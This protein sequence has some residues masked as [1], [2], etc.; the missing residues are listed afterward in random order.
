V[1]LAL[2]QNSKVSGSN[3]GVVNDTNYF[4]LLRCIRVQ[5]C[6]FLY[7]CQLPSSLLEPFFERICAA[8][9]LTTRYPQKTAVSAVAGAQTYYTPEAQ[10]HNL[11]VIVGA[12]SNQ[13]V[14]SIP[15]RLYSI[16]DTTKRRFTV[17]SLSVQGT[18]KLVVDL[19]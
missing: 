11:Y 7:V 4:L 17:C 10:L 14:Q 13:R 1:P 6:Q 8:K 2:R 9:K 15:S 19:C 16:C 5:V 12:S 3:I 18:L